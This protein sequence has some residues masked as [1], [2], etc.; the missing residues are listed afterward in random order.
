MPLCC[1][2]SRQHKRHYRHCT[3]L[4]HVIPSSDEDFCPLQRNQFNAIVTAVW[5]TT[6]IG[7]RADIV[8]SVHS[9]PPW[10]HWR[11]ATASRPPSPP[12]LRFVGSV[13]LSRPQTF[14]SV[15][16]PVSTMCLSGC[17][18]TACSWT[19]PKR[20]SCGVRHLGSKTACE[21]RHFVSALTLQSA[22]C[23]HDLGIYIDS[24]VFMLTH[25]SRT[26]SNCFSAL[27][28]LRSIQR[29]VSQLMLL[30][31]VTSL[32]LTRLDYGS[33]TLSV[34]PGHLLNRPQSVLKAA[35]CHVRKY[36]HVTHLLRD[37]HWLRVAG[38]IHYRLAVLVFHCRHAMAPPYFALDLRWT[39]EAEALQRLRS[40]S[41]Q[42][43][44]MRER[45][46]ARLMTV[47]SVWRRHGHGTG[48]EG[49]EGAHP[50][51]CRGIAIVSSISC[52]CRLADCWLAVL[53]TEYNTDLT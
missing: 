49:A 37:L 36:D 46:F 34:V 2:T 7:S 10:T 53:S 3:G 40:G 28:Q 11:Y 48:V 26:V 8:P 15:S 32:I 1:A 50:C 6:R 52:S 41:R 47:H 30:S 19:L 17:K 45:D 44:I 31:L 39:D 24:D 4:V 14:N 42:R 13:F 20:N 38:R 43:L 51:K 22:R 25:I 29:S 12:T 33:A 23:A 21:T 35:A 5:S 16:Q 9:R 27:R 18:R